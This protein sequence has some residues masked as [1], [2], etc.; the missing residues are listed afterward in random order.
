MHKDQRQQKIL[1]LVSSHEISKQE[2]LAAR[3]TRLGFSAT[4]ASV[5]RD[6]DELGITKKAGIYRLPSHQSSNG[7]S[8]V[9]LTN[10]GNSLIVAKC[11]PGLASA[12]T[13][14]IDAAGIKGIIGTIAGDDTV[15]IAVAEG[16]AQKSVT[17]AIW[18][19]FEND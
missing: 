8:P 5:S 12:V 2:V 11:A 7:P 9:S 17:K 13:V 18:E 19:L 16:S 10:A 4:Q 1:E 14:R 6:I 15:F 3:L